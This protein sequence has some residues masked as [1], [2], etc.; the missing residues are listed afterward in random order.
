M[1]DA[2]APIFATTGNPEEKE[3]CE[4]FVANAF[5]SCPKIK[6]MRE[7]LVRLGR[8]ADAALVRC[9]HCPDGVATAGGFLPDRD[10][11]AAPV[12]ECAQAVVKG[13]VLHDAA[14]LEPLEA[15]QQ[16]QRRQT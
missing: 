1:A 6:M 9:E 13:P 4:G 8:P 16:L 14:L 12:E 2:D 5:R 7:A 11:D 15:D 3:A 10:L